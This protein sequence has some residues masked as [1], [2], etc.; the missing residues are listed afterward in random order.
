MRYIKK[1][2]QDQNKVVFQI[3][4]DFEGKDL[5]NFFKLCEISAKSLRQ[6]GKIIFFGNGGSAADSQHLAT[7]LIVRFRKNRNS[8]SA[9][10]LTTDVTAISAIGN[11][12]SF[13]KIFSRQL[14]SL[15]RSG[16]IAVALTTSGNSKN[17]IEAA[18]VSRKKK[19]KMF[20]FSGNKGGKLR[21]YVDYP[22][23]LK[24]KNTAALQTCEVHLGQ[25]LCGYLEEKLG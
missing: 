2:I 9:L 23:I 21:K 8:I 15:G 1:K 14:E 11:D 22:I 24:S 3:L 4:K 25:I 5:D 10:A 19:I 12:F 18:K 13:E 6:K 16:D 7:E 17:L 20:C